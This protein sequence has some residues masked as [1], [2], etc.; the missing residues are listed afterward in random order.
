MPPHIGIGDEAGQD[1]LA[2]PLRPRWQPASGIGHLPHLGGQSRRDG[3][4]PAAPRGREAGAGEEVTADLSQQAPAAA[5]SGPAP[6]WPMRIAG[7]ADALLAITSAW[8]EQY[9]GPA[10]TVPVRSGTPTR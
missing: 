4:H 1:L 9:G 8:R 5:S 7:L 10:A 3:F 2:P 6:L